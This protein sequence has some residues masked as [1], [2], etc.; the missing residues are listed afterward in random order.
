MHFSIERKFYSFKKNQSF[1][2]PVQ[3]SKTNIEVY[4]NKKRY[5]DKYFI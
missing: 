3:I 5:V 4:K 1:A 2:A